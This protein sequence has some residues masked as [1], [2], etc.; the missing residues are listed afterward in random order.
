MTV[1]GAERK[2]VTLPTDFRSPRE[3]GHSRYGHLTARFAPQPTLTELAK[4]CAG[5]RA[6]VRWARDRSL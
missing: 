3:N 1:I 2:H 4:V 6:E 5:W